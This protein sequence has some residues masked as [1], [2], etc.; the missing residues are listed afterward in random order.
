MASEVVSIAL[1]TIRDLLIEE[2]KFLSGV[3]DQVKEVQAELIRMQCFLKDAD[4]RQLKEEIVCNYVR[5]IRRLAYRTENVLDKF[6]VQVESRRG[7]RSIGNAIKRSSCILCEGRALH[8]VG[9]EIANIKANINRLTT[10]LQTS[11]VIVMSIEGESSS[12]AMILEQNQQRLRQT[13]PHQVEEYFVGMKDDIRQLVTFITN[14][15]I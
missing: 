4:R 3:S 2:A 14:E 8:K 12:N 7:G 10:S 11:G 6:A 5:E 15:E 13:Y 1:G 9:S